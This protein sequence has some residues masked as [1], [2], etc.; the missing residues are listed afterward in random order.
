MLDAGLL[1]SERGSVALGGGALRKR[2]ARPR[3]LDWLKAEEAEDARFAPTGL[4][5]AATR[6]RRRHQACGGEPEARPTAQEPG[7]LLLH[8]SRPPAPCP[9][10]C[11][12]KQ[13][14][15]AHHRRFNAAP[16]AAAAASSGLTRP[17]LTRAP[18]ATAT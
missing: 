10:L 18:E 4:S 9:A 16:A 13:S 11:K 7:G 15:I 14:L 12:T 5:M 17:K 2:A 6:C 1:R 8:G 3:A